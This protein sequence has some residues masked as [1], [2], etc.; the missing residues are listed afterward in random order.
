[1]AIQVKT[2]E[3]DGKTYR[4]TT[5]G[6]EAALEWVPVLTGAIGDALGAL[7]KSGGSLDTSG[8]LGGIIGAAGPAVSALMS[9]LGG[10]RFKQLV[11]AMAE[12]TEVVLPDA[13]GS[14]SKRKLDPALRDELFVGQW[15]VFCV[16]LYHALEVN[17][18]SF[19]AGPLAGALFA[20]A[21]AKQ[22][23]ST[24]QAASTG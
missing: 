3:I 21:K 9:S 6:S 22:S 24:S 18:A 20:A 4:V 16:W 15:D 10:Q 17:F 2:K 14:L 11:H 5:L 19:F 1:M 23:A 13:S 12:K 8:G 7:T